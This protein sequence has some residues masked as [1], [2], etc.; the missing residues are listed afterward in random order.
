MQVQEPVQEPFSLPLAQQSQQHQQQ[1]QHLQQQEHQQP[2]MGLTTMRC[3]VPLLFLFR[4]L[5]C[6]QGNISFRK[7]KSEPVYACLSS[8]GSPRRS[9][10]IGGRTS[11]LS[12]PAAGVRTSG[13]F[14]GRC[15]SMRHRGCRRTLQV[16]PSSSMTCQMMRIPTA[17]TRR[18]KSSRT[19][20]LLIP[21][22]SFSV[23]RARSSRRRI[24]SPGSVSS[25]EFRSL[26]L[27]PSGRS[28]E[29]ALAAVM[30]STSTV[31]MYM[32]ASST[33]GA[34]SQLMKPFSTR[35][36]PSATRPACRPN[37]ATSRP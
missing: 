36:K 18:R 17:R 25:L 6:S 30:S 10:K 21:R 4:H 11:M 7:R 5:T 37:G 20:R 26:L 15:Q 35:C 13:C 33:P 19:A 27:G 31:I 12:R 28:R 23:R 1:Q 3:G 22:A 14:T 9:W 34:P 29:Y 8:V 16:T 32:P 2:Q 24:G